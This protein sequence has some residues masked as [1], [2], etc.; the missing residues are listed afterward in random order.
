[1]YIEPAPIARDKSG[2]NVLAGDEHAIDVQ[3]GL[4]KMDCRGASI[5]GGLH[6]KREGRSRRDWLDSFRTCQGMESG[7]KMAGAGD[8]H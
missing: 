7:R 1:M 2:W 5:V 6:L 4:G 3:V 8:V